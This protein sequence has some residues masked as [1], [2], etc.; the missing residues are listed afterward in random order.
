MTGIDPQ[1]H[2]KLAAEAEHAEANRDTPMVYR[3]K[4]SSNA[5][6]VY[7]LRLPNA[8]IEQL[9]QLAAARGMEPSNLA[10]QW[11]IEHLDAA[12]SGRDRDTERWERD[13]RATAEHMRQ[14][15]DERP[16]AA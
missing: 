15:L 16:A 9:R 7:G 4:R 3:R 5:Q 6:S 12:E 1:L 10:R 13:L 8:R 2:T 11:V 14:L